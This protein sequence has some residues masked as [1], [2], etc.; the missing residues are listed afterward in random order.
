MLILDSWM[1]YLGFVLAV[2]HWRVVL[3]VV[4]HEEPHAVVVAPYF[5]LHQLAQ[6]TAEA[7]W[8]LHSLRHRFSN[9]IL[10]NIGRTRGRH[11]GSAGMSSDFVW[12]GVMSLF[13]DG[14]IWSIGMVH[15]TWKAHSCQ[16]TYHHIH[17][18]WTSGGAEES[19]A[20]WQDIEIV[21]GTHENI[22]WKYIFTF[23]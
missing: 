12:D 1:C 2:V 8:N 7:H 4:T 18:Q 6:R 10:R 11:G 15:A 21:I 9:L 20:R 13:I 23:Y 19:D 5:G 3:V 17:T 14:G 16:L 22:S